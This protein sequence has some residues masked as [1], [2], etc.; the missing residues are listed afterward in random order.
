MSSKHTRLTLLCLCLFVVAGCPST[1]LP[2]DGGGGAMDGGLDGGGLDGGGGGVDGGGLDGGGL[3]GGGLDGG[4]GGGLDGG[5]DA[6]T[7]CAPGAD[8]R[9]AVNDCDVAE[10]CD[11]S[12]RCPVDGFRDA[13]VI[14]SA[15]ACTAGVAQPERRCAGTAALCVDAA[16]I[17]CNGYECRGATCGTTCASDTEC[18]ATHFCQAG[19]LCAPLRIDGQGCTGPSAGGE[20]VSGVCS[21]S[22][23]DADGDT[24]G[25][26]A[27]DYFCGAAAPAGRAA[28]AGDCCDTEARA[29]PGQT[30]YFSTA[31]SCGGFDFDCDRVAS[32]QDTS[33]DACQAVG[34][35]ATG[36]RDCGGDTGWSGA[37]PACGASATY[38]TTCGVIAACSPAT[39]PGCSACR[40]SSATR[41]Q[42]CR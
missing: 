35:C 41:T 32:R 23:L 31:S 21:G 27:I 39:C 17:S 11:P 20:C 30:S 19:G 38:V 15:A 9:P 5:T 29:F 13:A 12:G 4:G 7:E 1:P 28:R 42:A 25:T 14:C 8:C 33:Q 2:D 6:P 26:G 37:T 40:A 10:I 34:A 16:P 3:D 36:D 18:A 22:Y 24:H